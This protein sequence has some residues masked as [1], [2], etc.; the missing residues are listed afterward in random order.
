MDY[1]VYKRKVHI[2]ETY[3]KDTPMYVTKD[4]KYIPM[5]WERSWPWRER[6]IEEKY[7]ESGKLQDSTS[8]SLL[9]V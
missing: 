1:Y 9:K 4:N 8:G 5:E 7:G 2:E 3:S 6:R